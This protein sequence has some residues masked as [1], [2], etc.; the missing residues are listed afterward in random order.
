MSDKPAEAQQPEEQLFDQD[1]NPKVRDSKGRLVSQKRANQPY[2][3]YQKYREEEAK[4]VEEK[5]GRKRLREEKIARGE[6]PGPDVDSES[7]SLWDVVKTLLVLV[8]LVALTGQLVTGSLLWGTNVD[9]KQWWPT[10]K[11]MFSEAQL[12]K[13]D[14]VDP[15]KPVY[16]AIDGDVYDVSEGRRIY[17]PG[18]SY[19]SFA[20]KDAARAYTTG[21]FQTH[22]T[23]DIRGL[24]EKELKS[25]AHWKSFFVKTREVQTYWMGQ[26]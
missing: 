6:D 12:A 17:G 23:H 10:Q 24:N 5:A 22:L 20:G 25:L 3:A 13:F 1:G 4:R 14:G 2:L 9:V 19:H 16:I 15:L 21:C 8:G 11:T 18:G 7:W 26:T